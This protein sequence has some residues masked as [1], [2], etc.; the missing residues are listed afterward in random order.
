MPGHLPTDLLLRSACCSLQTQAPSKPGM[1]YE[2]VRFISS[3]PPLS[4]SLGL[5]VQAE[6]PTLPSYLEAATD[7]AAEHEQAAP[8]EAEGSQ[9]GLQGDEVRH[10]PLFASRVVTELG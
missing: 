2:T 6:L 8:E 5:Y 10:P 4:F 7:Q 3:N 9:Q 1:R